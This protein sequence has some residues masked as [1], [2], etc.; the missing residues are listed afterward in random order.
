MDNQP[1]ESGIQ[2]NQKHEF[3]PK[4]IG[5]EF[6]RQ[7]YTRLHHT[8]GDLH[9][10]YTNDS[11]FA[12]A[13]ID[14]VAEP[15]V[16]L[17]TGKQEIHMAMHSAALNYRNCYTRITLLD[18]MKTLEDGIFIQVSGEISNDGEPMRPFS[19]TF[20]LTLVGPLMYAVQ[21]E[22]FHYNDLKLPNKLDFL[23]DGISFLNDV[24]WD[25]N[26]SGWDRKKDGDLDVA[27]VINNSTLPQ[28][29]LQSI[30]SGADAGSSTSS[31]AAAS[32]NVIILPPS[33]AV[34]NF[35]EQ[36]AKSMPIAAY[37][38][39]AETTHVEHISGEGDDVVID[40][41]CDESGD[42]SVDLAPT[43]AANADSEVGDADVITDV[44]A[45]VVADVDAQADID[46]GTE[47]VIEASNTD[48]ADNALTNADLTE[49]TPSSPK[50]QVKT[51]ADQLKENSCAFEINDN[52]LNSSMMNNLFANKTVRKQK[53]ND[54][55]RDSF[56]DRSNRRKSSV[57][58]RGKYWNYSSNIFLVII[59]K[60]YDHLYKLFPLTGT[61]DSMR[62]L[63]VFIGNIDHDTTEDQIHTYFERYG[64]I[65]RFR[66]HAHPSKPWLP[67]YAF[68]SYETEGAFLKCLEDKVPSNLN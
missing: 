58:Y 59:E 63:Q 15:Q 38:Q 14:F 3:E 37:P 19:Q 67:N 33:M 47:T 18:A 9:N 56:H 41:T 22:I 43:V 50:E 66:M 23:D 20:V 64:R 49:S 21:N 34:I 31:V 60:Q 10:F 2:D 4:V 6:V 65:V 42:D 29:Y 54:F 26:V 35:A 25:N 57:S 11:K 32:T 53:G 68:V 27:A 12:H 62:S 40:L 48:H 51:W 36:Q 5:R 52:E 44:T 28:E 39:A 55:R 30:Q 1:V 17:A 8:P 45:D 61:C 13:A 16:I 46:A 7:Y 24:P